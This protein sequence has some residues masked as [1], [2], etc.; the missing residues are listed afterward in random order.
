MKKLIILTTLLF[1]FTIS[2]NAQDVT[3]TQEQAQKLYAE[4]AASKA[5]DKVIEKAEQL[6]QVRKEKADALQA[7]ANEKDLRLAEKDKRIAAQAEQIRLLT[8]MKCS[9]GSFLF[10]IYRYKRCS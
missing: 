3:L 6:A 1:A 5:K 4:V 8:K 9:K 10:I 2:A 7:L